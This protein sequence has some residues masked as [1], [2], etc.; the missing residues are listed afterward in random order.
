MM[1]SKALETATD[2]TLD[3]QEK[4]DA[5]TAAHAAL[6]AFIAAATAVDMAMYQAQAD[7]EVIPVLIPSECTRNSSR[8]ANPHSS[9]GNNNHL[10]LSK[11]ELVKGG[12]RTGM[13]LIMLRQIPL[14]RNGVDGFRFSCSRRIRRCSLRLFRQYLNQK[15]RTYPKTRPGC[16]MN[17]GPKESCKGPPPSLNVNY[18]RGRSWWPRS[19]RSCCR[20]FHTAQ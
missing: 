12:W 10:E 13:M 8:Q 20:P 14:S 18:R 6:I 17:G 5:A 4:L 11:F 3:T 1:K 7:S 2:G 19:R 16:E 15:T 9:L